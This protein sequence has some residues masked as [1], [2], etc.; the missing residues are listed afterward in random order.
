M[1]QNLDVG[2][3]INGSQ[4]QQ[5]NSIIEKY[6]YSDDDQNCAVYGGL[7]Q[8]D[9]A[10]QYLTTAGA[11]ICPGGWHLPTDAE[12]T[13]LI[14]FLSNESVAGGRMKEVGLSHWKSPN[15]GATN[16]S[17]FTGLPGDYRISD[18][19]FMNLMNFTIFWSSTQ[20]NAT[21]AWNRGLEYNFANFG[22][23]SYIKIAGFSVRCLHDYD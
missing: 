17:G 1:A 8:W 16:I 19:T 11:G 13:P 20:S 15:F 3:R 4:N 7:Y 2:T 5:N 18:G 23:N 12:W 6:C 22:L 14:T 21:Y 9:E 10:M